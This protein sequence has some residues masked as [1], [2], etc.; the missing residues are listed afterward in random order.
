MQLPCVGFSSIMSIA[1]ASVHLRN[2]NILWAALS[3][4]SSRVLSS[5]YQHAAVYAVSI[6]VL[7]FRVI[8]MGCGDTSPRQ[9]FQD[10]L[11]DLNPGAADHVKRLV[12]AGHDA[13][14]ARQRSLR[15]GASEQ[16]MRQVFANPSERTIRL[17]QALHALHLRDCMQSS[18]VTASSMVLCL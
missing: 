17:Y 5:R 11:A 9:P 2:N 13:E 15:V 7:L 12:A 16:E 14:A 8:C 3:M 4:M 1:A 6:P 10:L 18:A